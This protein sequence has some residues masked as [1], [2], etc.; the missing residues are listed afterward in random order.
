MTK[1]YFNEPGN[2]NLDSWVANKPRNHMLK[3]LWGSPERFTGRGYNLEVN[4][5]NQT[6]IVTF[7]MTGLTSDPLSQILLF[8]LFLVI[9][10][11]S[12]V[13]NL[14]MML[15]IRMTH[16]LHSPMYFFLSNLSLID[17]CFSS[18]IIPRML[19]DFISKTKPIASIACATQMFCFSLFAA[20]ES[21]LVSAMAYD[22]YVAICRPLVYHSIMVKTMCWGLT[23]G[24]YV[25]SFLASITIT[26]L[27]FPLCGSN[28]VINHFYCDIPPL[29]KLTCGHSQIRKYVV[30]VL[31]RA[32]GSACFLVILFSYVYIVHTILGIHSKNGRTK[33]F[34]TCASHL[35]V[36]VTFYTTSLGNYFRPE[37]GLNADNIGKVFS[38]FYTVTPPL[39]NPLIYSFKN[40][41][42]KSAVLKFFLLGQ[43]QKHS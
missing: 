12:F 34:S 39:L 33:A 42:V 41:E 1:V 20:S 14:C 19:A 40:T 11:C 27:V 13:C 28:T 3:V 16:H 8:A 26:L 18:S 22:R 23:L 5:M 25:C 36:V 24:A 10:L 6:T 17:L 38:I 37:T 35:A 31:T 43:I 29:L 30:I 32:I 2:V 21:L 9:Y 15:L 7:Y 4:I